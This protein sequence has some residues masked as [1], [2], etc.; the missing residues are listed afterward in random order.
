MANV[1]AVMRN[2]SFHN[3]LTDKERKELVE[4]IKNRRQESFNGN[5]S[6][7]PPPAG[8]AVEMT[9]VKVTV[10]EHKQSS[11]LGDKPWH[12]YDNVR[13]FNFLFESSL[14]HTRVISSTISRWC[15]GLFVGIQHTLLT[16]LH[17]R[18]EGLTTDEH[19]RLL[20][21]HG[22]NLIT[23]PPQIHW[24]VKF[25]FTLIGG[26]QMML[27]V[28]AILCFVVYGLT[29]REDTQTFVLAWVLIIVVFITSIFQSYQEGKSDETMA[30]LQKLTAT[31]VWYVCAVK[32]LFI[33]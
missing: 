2:M 11:G 32:Q 28:G 9:E 16:E 3:S 29:H 26:F 25:F 7:D 31:T 5:L 17:T 23:P 27:W 6:S 1:D 33:C 10:D 4:A 20:Q 21:R 19:L 15:G 24:L 18:L 8:A 13:V 12:T 14:A 22:K 30:A